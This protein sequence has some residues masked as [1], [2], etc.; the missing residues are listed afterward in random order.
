[1]LSTVDRIHVAVGV[2]INSRQEILLAKRAEHLHQGGLWEFPGGKVEKNETVE[3]ALY[4]ELDEELGIAVVIANPFIKVNHDYPDKSVL[5]DVWL[6]E[7]FTGTPIG[8][9]SQPLQWVSVSELK[10]HAVPPANREI[11]AALEN[12]YKKLPD[13]LMITGVYDDL[14][15][16]IAKLQ[17]ALSRDIRWVQLRAHRCSYDEYHV[18]YGLTDDLC[19]KYGA[20]L[21]V[22][23]SLDFFY[24]LH[25]TRLHFTTERLLKTESRP[26]AK[27]VLFGASCHNLTEIQHAERVDVDYII[28]GSVFKTSTHPAE[29]PIG[30]NQFADWAKKTSIPVFALGGL[31]PELK[32]MIKNVGGY[33][34]AAI[35]SYWQKV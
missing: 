10:R 7:K 23:T 11:V 34:L 4:R 13:E 31:N 14:D 26:V 18:L 9:E 16:Y 17:Y 24:Q 21:T 25:A 22:N 20:Q 1:M 12:R 6:V 29:E 35:S 8:N 30:L 28:L 33:G 27:S 32:A 15:D 19:K 3:E 2:I 5:L